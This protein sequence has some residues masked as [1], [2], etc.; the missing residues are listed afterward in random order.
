[1]NDKGIYPTIKD[2]DVPIYKCKFDYTPDYTPMV[3]LGLF[4]ITVFFILPCFIRTLNKFLF[5]K[6]FFKKKTLYQFLI[7]DNSKK[8]QK[9]KEKDKLNRI[10]ILK[11]AKRATDGKS[12]LQEHPVKRKM[13]NKSIYELKAIEE[14]KNDI[15]YTLREIPN[16][17]I[18]AVQKIKSFDFTPSKEGSSKKNLN[19][20]STSK[21]MLIEE[22]SIGSGNEDV[23]YSRFKS[24]KK[25]KISDFEKKMFDEMDEDVIGFSK[26]RTVTKKMKIKKSIQ[27]E[28]DED[29]QGARN[30]T[31]AKKMKILKR[32]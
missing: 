29:V 2:C 11:E 28:M 10:K 8:L 13:K 7:S 1:M 3:V 27:D 30:S 17:G 4:V 16:K 26:N 22:G 25:N 5:Q 24:N 31:S 18:D 12:I 21:K 32:R 19:G 14:D 20:D 9:L 6:I 23:K 15:P